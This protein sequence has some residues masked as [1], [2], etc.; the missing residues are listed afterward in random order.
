MRKFA[1]IIGAV[2]A[3]SIITHAATDEYA[4]HIFSLMKERDQP[5]RVA[6][7]PYGDLVRKID[8]VS[9]RSDRQ[10]N[11]E[12]VKV[13]ARRHSVPEAVAVALIKQ[14]S[15]FNER[16]HSYQDA[17]GM[18]QILPSTWRAEGCS[19]SMWNAEDSADCSMRYL[20]K[21]IRENGLRDGI[22]FYHG[23]PDRRQWGR[24]TRA[25]QRII[26]ASLGPYG[27]LR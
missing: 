12:I 7:N 16:A 1:S 26:L 11:V 14:E 24:K 25:Y 22:A 27:G 4:E 19:G 8:R 20:A 5:M 15:G 18:G 17:R 3:S 21:G 2:I 13:A 10:R 9:V 23:G 6:P